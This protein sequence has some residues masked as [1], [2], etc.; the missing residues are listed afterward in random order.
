MTKQVLRSRIV[1]LALLSCTA[2]MSWAQTT[3]EVKLEDVITVTE[4]TDSD[5]SDVADEEEPIYQVVEQ[6]PEFPGGMSAQMKFL[7][8]NLRYPQ[9][10]REKGFQGRVITQFVVNTD[11]SIS[12]IKIVK[13]LNPLLEAEALRVIR[14]MPK[15]NP[16]KQKGKTV[17]VRYTFPIIFRL[18]DK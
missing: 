5:S 14:L 6:Q 1:A 9:E 8:D 4:D 15:W 2:L 3:S 12:D 7:Q 10:A 11:G 17:R 16:G 18:T 13:P